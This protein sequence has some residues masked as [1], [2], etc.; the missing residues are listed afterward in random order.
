MAP[1][2]ESIYSKYYYEVLGGIAGFGSP[3][4]KN[5]F[6]KRPPLA[7]I[8]RH[9]AFALA[10]VV[11]GHYMDKYLTYRWMERDA[12]VRHYIELHPE[13]F[14]EK[15]RKYKEVFDVWYPIR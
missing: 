12:M 3:I 14:E 15:K 1:P 7:G 4:V 8:Q 11:I 2:T 6:N 9:I 5:Y 13:D 10:G